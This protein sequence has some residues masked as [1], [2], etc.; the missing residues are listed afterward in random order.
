MARK[1]CAS[2]RWF[3]H[4]GTLIQ[5]LPQHGVK[6]R[7]LPASVRRRHLDLARPAGQK[8]DRYQE[9][10]LPAAQTRMPKIS[11]CA[12][13]PC[14]LHG[15]P[16]SDSRHRHNRSRAVI[17]IAPECSW[18]LLSICALVLGW[19]RPPAFCARGDAAFAATATGMAQL[20]PCR[21]NFVTPSR[22][23][24]PTFCTHAWQRN[25]AATT[26]IRRPTWRRMTTRL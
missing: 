3:D 25:R 22:T 14:A 19:L 20:A 8:S 24:H 26:V 10:R 1:A 6:A 2:A 12:S 18:E 23:P 7:R 15:V 17:G 11:G 21:F 4:C 5:P 13:A 16:H 9:I